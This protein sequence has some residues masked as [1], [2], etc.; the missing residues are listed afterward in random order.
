MRSLLR[1]T[2]PF[3]EA[4][5]AHGLDGQGYTDLPIRLRTEEGGLVLLRDKV[6]E[7]SPVSCLVY[8]N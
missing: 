1:E 3:T 5:T 7:R 6:G 8:D 2:A 4:Y